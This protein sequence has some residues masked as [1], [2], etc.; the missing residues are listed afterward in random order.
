MK[1]LS[2]IFLIMFVLTISLGCPGIGR[3]DKEAADKAIST[4]MEKY[5][6]EVVDIKIFRDK[7]QIAFKKDT[8]PLKKSQIFM[9][10]ATLWWMSYPKDK[11]P[12]YKLSC[13]AYDDV[14]SDDDIG[15]LTLQRGSNEYPRV[16]GQPGI[17]SLRDVK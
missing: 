11:K 13:W 16:M 17:Y 4:I 15:G 10:A 3:I 2:F 5:P 1:K 8:H 12:R 9:E 6:E 14:I 7:M